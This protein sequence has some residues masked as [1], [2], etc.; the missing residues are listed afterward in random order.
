MASAGCAWG[1]RKW[2][3]QWNWWKVVMNWWWMEWKTWLL[4]QPIKKGS[5]SW[6]LGFMVAGVG[7]GIY[8][9]TRSRGGLLGIWDLGFFF[10]FNLCGLGQGFWVSGWLIWWGQDGWIW[11][12]RSAGRLL[13]YRFGGVGLGERSL[14]VRDG[15]KRGSWWVWLRRDEGGYDGGK[16]GWTGGLWVKVG[17]GKGLWWVRLGW[18]E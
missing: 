2:W 13:G 17:Q 15:G 10:F 11:C 4:S 16:L 12:W 5:F 9:A 8:A 14:G 3:N 6:G 7:E 18:D 1:F